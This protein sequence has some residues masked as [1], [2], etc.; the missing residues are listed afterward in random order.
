VGDG[1]GVNGGSWRIPFDEMAKTLPPLD[2]SKSPT[3]RHRLETGRIGAR[4]Q[5]GLILTCQRDGGIGWVVAWCVVQ[6]AYPEAGRLGARSLEDLASDGH[7]VEG[8]D[9]ER[10]DGVMGGMMRMIPCVVNAIIVL[11]PS[12]IFPRGLGVAV[13]SSSMAIV[14]VAR[15]RR[16]LDVM[17]FVGRGKNAVI[18]FLGPGTCSSLLW[19]FLWLF[20]FLWLVWLASAFLLQLLQFALLVLVLARRDAG[21]ASS[22]SSS[23]S[24]SQDMRHHPD[25]YQ[26]TVTQEGE[27]TVGEIKGN[28]GEQKGFSPSA[29]L[30]H[31]RLHIYTVYADG[32][33]AS[34]AR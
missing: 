16:R 14:V 19:L 30:D 26:G 22:S 24:S 18:V 25:H 9:A 8:V 23:S 4:G 11:S 12:L 29:R 6:L 34:R 13:S 21:R 15:L 3:H 33:A 20:L 7:F 1:A 28:R 17:A 5:H 31:A 2:L 32:F 10:M 27:T